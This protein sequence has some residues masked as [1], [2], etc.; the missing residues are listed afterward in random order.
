MANINLLP[1]REELRQEK[2]RQFISVLGLI[3]ILG[4]AFMWSMYTFYENKL[5]NQRERNNFLQS[6]VRKLDSK[7]KEIETLEKERQELVERM[8][9]I[10]NLQKSRPQV[11]HLFDEIVSTMPEGVNLSAIERK[12][13]DITMHG[14][15]ESGPRISNFMRNIS[16]SKWLKKELLDAISSDKESGANRKKFVLKAMVSSP[17]NDEE[18]KK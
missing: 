10:Q 12:G 4:V 18:V 9:L 16:T 2:Q 7:I 8:D 1:W 11:V 13:D 14:I 15:A 17:S 6:E 3:A 5:E